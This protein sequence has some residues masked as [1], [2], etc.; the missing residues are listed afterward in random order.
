MTRPTL[1]DLYEPAHAVGATP[2]GMFA[3]PLYVGRSHPEKQ[4]APALHGLPSF[5]GTDTYAV[6]D[7]KGL[8]LAQVTVAAGLP[9]V[10][11]HRLAAL[12]LVWQE[13]REPAPAP[14]HGLALVRPELSP[15]SPSPIRTR[16][17][18]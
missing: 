3:V 17:R 13:R 9:E 12:L 16:R 5:G 6:A 1:H 14:R 15:R 11:K 7:A 4:G 10:D 18:P 2:S 8:L